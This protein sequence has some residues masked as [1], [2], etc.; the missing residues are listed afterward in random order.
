MATLCRAFVGTPTSP[1]CVLANIESALGLDV[2]DTRTATDVLATR[3]TRLSILLV[4][5]GPAAPSKPHRPG[6]GTDRRCRCG[7]ASV[8]NHVTI[9]ASGARLLAS[10]G[11]F[12][13]PG[14]YHDV[15]ARR[16]GWWVLSRCGPRR[17]GQP[18]GP[19]L[20]LTIPAD[21]PSMCLSQADGQVAWPRRDRN[22]GTL[23]PTAAPAT[24]SASGPGA[25]CRGRGTPRSATRAPTSSR[26]LSDAQYA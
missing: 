2:P 7:R 10:A 21:E 3:S 5:G 17:C 18:G 22:P 23:D 19:A 1:H 14:R 15:P 4:C 20:W 8:D 6:T 26:P 12:E 11:P 25:G 9:R 16:A 13:R 24:S